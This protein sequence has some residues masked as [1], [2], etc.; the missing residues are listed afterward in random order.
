M[1]RAAVETREDLGLALQQARLA[2]GLSQRDVAVRIGASQRYVWEL[3]SGR[4]FTAIERLLA[5]LGATGAQLVVEVPE[6]DVD[7]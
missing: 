2:A 7:G 1:F 5:M 4:D 6:G 3:E